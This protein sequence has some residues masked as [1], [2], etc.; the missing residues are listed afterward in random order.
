MNILDKII[1]HKQKEIARRKD[2]HPIKD[3]EKASYFERTTFSLC[4]FLQGP[5]Q[6]GVIAEF[7]RKSPSKGIINAN[8]KIEEVTTGYV[9]AGA[10][11]LSVLTDFNFFGGTYTDLTAARQL[12][13]V[14]ILNKNFII[15]EYQI[16]EAKSVGADVILL[17]AECLEKAALK[18]LAEFANSLGL[19]VL[20]EVH[21]KEQLDKLCAAV[22]LV[23]VNN[24][25]LKTFEVSIQTSY[26]LAAYIPTDFVK[27]A[28]SGISNPKTVIELKE[29][30]FKGFLIGEH[31]MRDKAPGE[32]C[33][34][35][36]KA[37]TNP[38]KERHAN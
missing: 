18:R 25:N 2:L 21:S 37:L 35:F 12:N 19:E 29:A 10:S 26:E 34:R 1:A 3:L 23:G 38:I 4:Q 11:A 15:E 17:I 16:I 30:G 33:T 13:K 6:M 32:A 27:V 28:E 14:P 31:F 20:L 22:N 7:K 5:K 24:R 8:A 9:Q 36:H